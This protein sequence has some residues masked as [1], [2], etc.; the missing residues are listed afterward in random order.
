MS[1]YRIRTYECTLRNLP[2]EMHKLILLEMELIVFCTLNST[3]WPA[4]QT[5]FELQNKTVTNEAYTIHN[6]LETSSSLI[7]MKKGLTATKC[8]IRLS[9][10]GKIKRNELQIK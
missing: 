5:A 7:Y 8:N 4:Q 9:A 10:R 2:Y 1:K 3:S 6:S